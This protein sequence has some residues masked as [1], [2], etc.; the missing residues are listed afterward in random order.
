MARQQKQM[1]LGH[2]GLAVIIWAVV[3][4]SQSQTVFA[5][6]TVAALNA[7]D[8]MTWLVKTVC[9][10]RQNHVLT[11]DPYFGCPEAA[12]V[13]KIQPGDPLRYHNVDQKGYQ[14]RDAFPVLDTG[15]GK[16]W[17][18][19]TFDYRPFNAF[20][21]TNGTDGYDVLALQN[22]WANAVNT[23]DGGGYGQTFF[24]SDCTIG[25]GWALFPTSGFLTAGET[26]I[27]ISDVYWEQSGQSYP[28]ACPA[29]YSTNTL[30]SWKH[31]TGFQFGGVNGN[32]IKEMDTIISYH[33]FQP[34]PGFLRNGHL[35]VFYFTREYGITR[36]EVW[37]PIQQNPTQTAECMVPAQMEYQKVMFVVQ[38]CHDWSKV[39][40][41]STADIPIWPVP[42]IN[43]LWKPHFDGMITPIWTAAGVTWSVANSTAARDAAASKVGVRYLA[44][45][46]ES[47]G[48]C[49]PDVFVQTIY[50]DVPSSRF[51]NGATYGFGINVRTESGTGGIA[52]GIEQIDA[53]GN[54]LS[55][56]DPAART[57]IAATVNP[58]NGTPG[59]ESAGEASSVYLSSLAAYTRTRIKLAPDTAKIRF[60]ISPRTPQTFDVLNA[61]LAPWPVPMQ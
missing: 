59:L 34:G 25:G 46:C 31:Q 29:H 27:P 45:G 28:G 38:A 2:G 41:A 52:V 3:L 26:T 17:V 50:Q 9:T 4:G 51:V 30:T 12:G 15:N 47:S 40:A 14:Q 5:G 43:L 18:I 24:T 35:E 54:V 60:L 37:T 32:P 57:A 13:R 8:P 42:N 49:N 48:Q 53:G 36:W 33:G 7:D 1:R 10:N 23:S 11:N 22:G 21:L 39:A 58:D 20:N 61:W 16:T 55:M 56:P 19:A 44:I 6:T